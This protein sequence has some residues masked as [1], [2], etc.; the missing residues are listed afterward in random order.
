VRRENF[1]Q[2]GFEKPQNP[3]DALCAAFW[4]TPLSKLTGRG[5]NGPRDALKIMLSARDRH[6]RQ[7]VKA[8]TLKR[9]H[10]FRNE[11]TLILITHTKRKVWLYKGRSPMSVGY[12][13]PLINPHPLPRGDQVF[14]LFPSFWGSAWVPRASPRRFENGNIFCEHPAAWFWAPSPCKGWGGVGV[15][16]AHQFLLLKANSNGA[17]PDAKAS[18]AFRFRQF[19]A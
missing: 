16:P 8:P 4:G 11:P 19:R 9:F 7:R 12:S 1:S 5:S 18:R 3:R 10:F 13:L 6:Q 15:A 2:A 17:L 14:A